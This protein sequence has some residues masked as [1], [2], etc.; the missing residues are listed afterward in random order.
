[1]N[2]DCGS[3]FSEFKNEVVLKNMILMNG[4]L[5]FPILLIFTNIFQKKLLH[6][7]F[8][9]SSGMHLAKLPK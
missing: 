1:M 5:A 2:K 9:P 7:R 4:G 8:V 3:R 6:G